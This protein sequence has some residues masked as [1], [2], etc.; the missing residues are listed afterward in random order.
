MRRRLSFFPRIATALSGLDLRRNGTSDPG[1]PSS[2]LARSSQKL[3]S[4]RRSIHIVAALSTM[5]AASCLITTD[6]TYEPPPKTAPFFLPDT[7]SPNADRVLQVNDATSGLKFSALMQSEDA[8]TELDARLY[9]DYGTAATSGK[10]Y[11]L[12]ID[13]KQ[14]PPGSWSDGPREVSATYFGEFES[15]DDGCHRFTLMVIHG[16]FDDDTGC[17]EEDGDYATQTWIVQNCG[18]AAIDNCLPFDAS[19][20]PAVLDNPSSKCPPST[21]LPDNAGGSP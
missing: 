6:P 21:V 19:L 18:D 13:A 5:T 15:M 8:G 14:P 12:L 17:P 4:V 3:G 10:V 20:C 1:G 11:K 2:V 9:L 7:A 16:N